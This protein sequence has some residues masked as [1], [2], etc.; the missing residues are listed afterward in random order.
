MLTLSF[1]SNAKTIVAKGESNSAFGNYTIE[2]LDDHMML[3]NKELDKYLITYENTDMKVV[4][5]MDK[6]KKCKKYYV[7]NDQLPV[8]YECNGTYFGIKKLEKAV[9]ATGFENPS[10][11]MN[12][13][14]FFNQRVLISGVTNTLD[15]LNLIA[16]YYPGLFS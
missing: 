1:A 16:S 10:E 7:L 14:E 2:Q 8:Q 5:V 11:K 3:N 4:V 15:H 6:Q 9:V 13:Q 12:K